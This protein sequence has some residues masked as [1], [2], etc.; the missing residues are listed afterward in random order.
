MF[1]R[2]LI[3]LGLIVVLVAPMAAHAS[4]GDPPVPPL[5]PADTVPTNC[6][7]QPGSVQ[8]L[9]APAGTQHEVRVTAPGYKCVNAP[10]VTGISQQVEVNRYSPNTKTWTI[11]QVFQT[12]D[13]AG[14]SPGLLPLNQLLEC[15]TGGALMGVQV[16]VQF[17]H[18][19][20]LATLVRLPGQSTAVCS[21]TT[22]LT[23]IYPLITV[24]HPDIV[25]AYIYTP[26]ANLTQ[27]GLTLWAHNAGVTTWTKVGTARTDANGWAYLATQPRWWTAYRW[28]WAG[29]ATYAASTSPTVTT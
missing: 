11:E 2:L 29:N 22:S 23:W 14:Q 12:Q 27:A 17:L 4:A 9:P 26:Y 10:L 3:V 25:R 28:T 15:Y 8:V 16:D 18:G 6:T 1:R 21:G 7:V 24:G 13:V 19:K 20:Q 5:G